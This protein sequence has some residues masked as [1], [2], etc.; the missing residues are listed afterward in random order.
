MY[1]RYDFKKIFEAEQLGAPLNPEDMGLET[2]QE[3]QSNIRREGYEL[4]A[5]MSDAEINELLTRGSI[6]V[7]EAN[8]KK[9]DNA[10]ISDRIKSLTIETGDRDEIISEDDLVVT[11]KLTKQKIDQ[12]IG[13]VK[14]GSIAKYAVNGTPI[15]FIK[16]I[17]TKLS[18]PT[19]LQKKVEADSI[20]PNE[21]VRTVARFNEFL[22]EGRRDEV[23]DAFEEI[24]K[25][26]PKKKKS[27][28]FKNKKID[29]YE[30]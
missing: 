12:L 14:D 3:A 17:E 25:I 24:L 26:I 10:T 21:S 28:K 16:D 20:L 19:D 1:R 27:N 22:S 13:M 8:W 2:N 11:L 29:N 9:L 18:T 5:T 30:F 23:A 6:E 4:E 7:G 15:S